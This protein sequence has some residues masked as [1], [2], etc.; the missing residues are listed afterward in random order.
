MKESFVL[1]GME[2]NKY[3]TFNKEVVYRGEQQNLYFEIMTQGEINLK[4]ISELLS[5]FK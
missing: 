1:N 3:E 2:W 5:S 4:L